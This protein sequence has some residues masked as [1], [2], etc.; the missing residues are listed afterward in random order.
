MIVEEADGKSVGM[1]T[2][3]DDLE[4]LMG[5]LSRQ[6]E[7][8]RALLGTLKKHHE[9]LMTHLG[10]H[11]VVLDPQQIPRWALFPYVRMGFLSGGRQ[12]V[13]L[14]AYQLLPGDS[15]SGINQ[16]MDCS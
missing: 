13:S 15:W 12:A 4:T 3:P 16:Q 8:E 11:S 5:R 10:A 6:G 14:I 9:Q 1:L 2:K 7:R